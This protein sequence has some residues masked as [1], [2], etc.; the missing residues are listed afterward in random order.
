[1]AGD[2]D[3][4][5][6][7]VEDPA[8]PLLGRERRDHVEIVLGRG[9]AEEDVAQ[10]LDLELDA[11]RQAVEEVDLLGG[12]G[13]E[14]PLALA[15]RRTSL[16]RRQHLDQLALGI[17]AQPAHPVALGAKPLDRLARKG[18]SDHVPTGHDHVQLG[19]LGEHRLERRQVPV[20]VV[21]RRDP[22]H[23]LRCRLRTCGLRPRVRLK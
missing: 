2:D 17:A 12:Q 13:G 19:S 1:M 4:G 18:A 3:V 6:H 9:V 14:E 23:R 8:Q 21:E 16:A 7:P 15:G 20:D 5:T 22:R 10:A 11:L